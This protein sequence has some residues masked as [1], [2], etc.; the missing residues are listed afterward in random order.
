MRRETEARARMKAF[1]FREETDRPALWAV[2]KNPD[3]AEKKWPGVED[4]KTR[5]LLPEYHGMMFENEVGR[6]RYHAEA[7]PGYLL[8]WGR[9]LVTLAVFA[10]G[11]Y[12]Y[13]GDN[14]YIEPIP[15]LYER[16][17]PRFDSHCPAAKR[18]EDIYR[19][20]SRSAKSR[21]HLSP[22]A[23]M[24]GLT[25]LSRFRGAEQLCLDIYECPDTVKRW[26]SALTDIYIAVHEHYFLLL[27]SLG[28]GEMASWLKV[29]AEGRFE[30][31]QCDFAVMLSPEMFQ[32]FVLPDLHAVTGYL[33][34]SLYHLDGVEQMRFLDLLREC[35]KLNGI[36]WN[37]Q[38]GVGSLTDFV[39]D[40]RRIR[41]RDFSL[42]ITCSTV[43][44][45]VELT[46]AL[47]PD[48]LFL[49]LPV[50]DSE[51]DVEHAIR[52]I[53]RA[54]RMRTKRCG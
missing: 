2:S 7:M 52:A 51:K 34:F 3:F 25:T 4:R 49:I 29:I 44:E 45:A 21:G 5:E 42:H 38:P 36:Q 39:D 30:A 11:N 47:G 26:S 24:D 33:D 14:A 43:D 41:E 12:N 50:F 19:E 28:F 23:M 15:D 40:F 48:G 17:L 6:Y 53:D 46:R 10:G 18:L 37:P 13:D 22:P 1:W 16:R 31:V 20:L 27:A 8:S 32:E 54:S 9:H 35:P